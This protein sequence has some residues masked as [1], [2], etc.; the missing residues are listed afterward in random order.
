MVFVGAGLAGLLAMI[1][2][3]RTALYLGVLA[4]LI[5]GAFIGLTN[6]MSWSPQIWLKGR[7]EVRS[8]FGSSY[9]VA[10]VVGLAGLGLV[11]GSAITS[12]AALLVAGSAG[13]AALLIVASP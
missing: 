3:Q 6:T 12:A 4:I 7:E 5:G 11:I 2:A 13:I 8:L 1:G 9:G 10:A